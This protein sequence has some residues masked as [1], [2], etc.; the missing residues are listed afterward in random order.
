LPFIPASIISWA[1]FKEANP[2][3][4]VLSRDTGFDRPYGSNPYAGYDRV[5]RPPFLFE[6]DID[7]RLLP[8]ERVDA[9]NIGDV[10][11]AF[12]FPLLETERVVN[13]PVNGTDV[14]VFFKPG[15]VSALDR[16]LIIDSDD[17]GSTGVFDAN[18]DG[19]KLTFSLKNDRFVDDQTGTSWNILG[20]ALEGEMAGKSLTPIV[21]GNHFWFAWGAFNPDTL[22]YKGQ[23]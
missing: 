20:E 6:G 7:G 16:A 14:V 3:S 9:I 13:Y 8:K 18:L 5:D 22:I 10:S 4:L 12:P 23:G 21:H 2:D 1:D 11:A 17:V 15:T 19:Q